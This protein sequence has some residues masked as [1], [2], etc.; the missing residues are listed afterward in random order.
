MQLLHASNASV[1]HQYTERI[2]TG[3]WNTRQSRLL[4]TC[5]LHISVSQVLR[6][7]HD[8]SRYLS[9]Y[10]YGLTMAWW[11]APVSP[12]GI[13]SAPQ[14][15]LLALVGGILGVS[16][17]KLIPLCQCERSD[18]AFLSSADQKQLLS[19]FV[20]RLW[21]HPLTRYPGPSLAALTSWPNWH[22]AAQGDRHV[23]LCQLHSR[24]GSAVRFAPNS[25]SFNTVTAVDAIY[26]TRKA[27]VVK[28]DWYQSVR[29]SA[30]GFEST[31]T[32]RDKPRH[33][34]KRRLLSNAFSERA[35]RGYEPRIVKSIQ[36]W[37]DCLEQAGGKTGGS[38]D[39]GRWSEYLIFDILGDLCFGKPFGLLKSDENRFIAKL[40]PQATRSWY[41]VSSR[42]DVFRQS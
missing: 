24:Y 34:V 25:I 4:L 35:L 29:D 28:S 27:D 26:K 30:G 38:V 42:Q 7:D 17:R 36:T 12:F 32:A 33:G 8:S 3:L 13:Y 31:F 21:L 19:I 41:T 9:G 20:Y 6:A 2:E 11:S 10:F 14:F 40:V 23:W 39:L 1:G 5:Q 16:S 15:L 18:T 22:H 37:L